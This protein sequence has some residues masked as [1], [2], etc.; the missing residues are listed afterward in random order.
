M[1][2]KQ[3]QFV[4][5]M[6]VVAVIT[7]AVILFSSFN[8]TRKQHTRFKANIAQSDSLAIMPMRV[9]GAP[10]SVQVT[11]F[12]GQEMVLIFWAS[13]SDKSTAMLDEIERLQAERDSLPVIAALVKDAE[14]SLAEEK[15]YPE[16][17]SKFMLL[18]AM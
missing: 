13:W 14:E 9:V 16:R 3:E 4:P 11:D 5:F 10:D 8:F 18:V 6:I 17:F 1:R 7:M 12:K 15:R 2:L